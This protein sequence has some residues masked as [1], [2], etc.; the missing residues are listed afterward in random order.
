M[1]R[2]DTRQFAQGTN[3]NKKKHGPHEYSHL[4]QVDTMPVDTMNE[5]M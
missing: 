4:P 5:K 1:K 2:H 3:Q